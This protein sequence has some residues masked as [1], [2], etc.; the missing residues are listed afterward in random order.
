M[1][2]SEKL[3]QLRRQSGLSQ[4][5]AAER[6]GVS[7]QSI[8]KWETD[9]SIPDPDKLVAL[10]KL[11]AVTTDYLLLESVPPEPPLQ[12]NT[13]PAGRHHF[14]VGLIL[15]LLGAGGLLFWGLAAIFFPSAAEQ[16]DNSSAVTLNGSGILALLCVAA[17]AAGAVLFLRKNK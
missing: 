15:C 12:S 14:A 5:Q 13:E 11:Y 16:L 10:S 6:L 3:Y 2:L 9:Q 1:K 4:E 7:R 17:L 8:S